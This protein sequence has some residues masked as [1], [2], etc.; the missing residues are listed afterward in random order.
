MEALMK[1]TTLDLLPIL[2][3]SQ[4]FFFNHG[5]FIP[6]KTSGELL[7]FYRMFLPHQVF[8]C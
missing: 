5:Y 2:T 6:F 1:N 3:D 4:L 7:A 8:K